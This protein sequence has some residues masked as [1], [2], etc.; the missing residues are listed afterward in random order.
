MPDSNN[1]SIQTHR[2]FHCAYPPLILLDLVGL[3][4]GWQFIYTLD[5][6]YIHL[7]LAKG[8]NSFHYGINP[9][10][11]SAPSSSVLWPFLMAPFASMKGFWLAPL[12]VNLACL[13]GTILVLQ[14]L[15][16][17]RFRAGWLASWVLASFVAFCLNIY[18]L[19]FT[20][21]EHSLQVLLV[22]IIAASLAER[23]SGFLLWGS[24]FLLPLIRYEGLAISIP[25]ICYLGLQGPATRTK[26]LWT[27]LLLAAALVL[28]SVFLGSLG[29]GYLPSSVFAKQSATTAG[30]VFGLARSMAGSVISN[31]YSLPTFTVFS[32]AFLSE[33]MAFQ[34]SWLRVLML[35]LAPVVLHL[36]LGR[37]GWFGRYEVSILLYALIISAD[38]WTENV[39][40]SI[41][42]AGASAPRQV[43]SFPGLLKKQALF[44]LMVIFVIGTRPLWQSTLLT[45]A[46]A[47]NIQDQQVQMALIAGKYLNKPV[48]V[49]DLGAVALSSRQ[50]VLDLWGLGSYEALSL[51][52]DPNAD[53]RVWIPRLMADKKV[54]HAIVYDSWF[55][56]TPENWIKVAELK[57]PG[58]QITPA[59]DV[60]AFYATSPGSAETM[61]DSISHYASDHPSEAQM[62]KTFRGETDRQEM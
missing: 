11:Y 60:V 19:V 47:R 42:G 1:E 35:L 44:P 38:L 58:R 15:L 54:E 34:R 17:S 2:A 21:M 48:A 31:V 7:A 57:L 22:A 13:A 37:N 5:D 49:N 25:V 61:S 23:R 40:N 43:R 29:L 28:F 8:I 9:S 41:Q 46:A 53:P 26:A 30:S 51:R 50:Y 52:R 33:F 24:L 16:L 18:G 6:P 27:G 12:I 59:S 32:L 3:I 14:R 39:H 36:C 62:I 4:T 55:P 10:E 20:G 45:P 56:V